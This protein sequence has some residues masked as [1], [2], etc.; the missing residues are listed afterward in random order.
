MG[1]LSET[2]ITRSTQSY[3]CLGG[4][5]SFQRLGSYQRKTDSIP[6]LSKLDMN[7]KIYKAS[8]L[9]NTEALY[10]K[11]VTGFL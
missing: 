11:L 5:I 2:K 6:A 3:V 8:I 7:I 1:L 4:M 10:K 9:W